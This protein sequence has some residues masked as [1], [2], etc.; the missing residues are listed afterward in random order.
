MEFSTKNKNSIGKRGIQCEK[1]DRIFS[2]QKYGYVKLLKT[3]KLSSSNIK[4]VKKKNTIIF[5]E[6]PKSTG[7][8]TF[9]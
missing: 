6:R 7:I 1:V 9:Y 8:C 5:C 4:N 2:I 3:H